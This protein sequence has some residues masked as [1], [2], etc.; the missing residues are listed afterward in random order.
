MCLR[1]YTEDPIICEK[2]I[3]ALSLLSDDV[4]GMGIWIGHTGGC[5]ALIGTAHKPEFAAH[6]I[7]CIHLFLFRICFDLPFVFCYF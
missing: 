6:N 7:L 5:Q 1:R 3:H 4:L 2:C